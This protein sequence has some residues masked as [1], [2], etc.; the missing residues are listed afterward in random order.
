[1]RKLMA[2]ALAAALGCTALAQVRVLIVDETLGFHESMR[3]E[4]LARALRPAG[5][6]LRAVSSFPKEPWTGEPF[7]FVIFLPAQGPYIWLCS[8]GPALPEPLRQAE[9]G[10]RLAL[11]KA[12]SGVRTVRGWDEDLLPVILSFYFLWQG[13]LPGGGR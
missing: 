3:L 2:V 7:H 5:F 11:E 8:P 9:S 13:Y 1:M 4:A 6:Q 12:F 10:L